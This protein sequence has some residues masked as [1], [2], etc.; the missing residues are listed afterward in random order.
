MTFFVANDVL[1]GGGGGGGGVGGAGGIQQSFIWGGSEVFSS[2]GNFLIV[3]IARCSL[4]F[5]VISSIVMF[6]D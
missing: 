6:L 2:R 3:F 1:R 5:K 4:R